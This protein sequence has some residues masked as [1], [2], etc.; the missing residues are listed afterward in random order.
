M[1][2]QEVAKVK[3]RRRQNFIDA[4]PK[5]L[6]AFLLD[7]ATSSEPS[8]RLFIQTSSALQIKSFP[9]SNVSKRLSE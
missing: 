3:K 9:P 8:S 6:V 2:D 5:L 7:T 1:L 4:N